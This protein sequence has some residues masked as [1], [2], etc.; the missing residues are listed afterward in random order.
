MNKNL[1]EVVFI[2]DRSGSM[3]GLETDTIG[4]YNSMLEK[5]KNEEGTALLTTILFDNVVEVLHDRVD[6][7]E[8]APITEKEYYVRGCT[9]L[10]DAVGST[11]LRISSAHRQEKDPEKVPAKTIFIITTDGMENASRRYNHEMVRELIATQKDAYGWEF[12]FLGADID[13]VS[14]AGNL[15]IQAT[16]AV[17]YKKDSQGQR[18]KYDVMSDVVSTARRA[19]STKAMS[20]ALEMDT[21]DRIRK[22]YASRADKH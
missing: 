11:I 12:I 15:G 1:T 8:V 3:G 18:L 20:D 13:A 17:R 22:D 21:L 14:V 16:R 5:Q 6:I 7:R 2:L 4:G 10:L 19:E 9:A